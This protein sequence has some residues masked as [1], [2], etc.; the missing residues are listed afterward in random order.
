MILSNHK[1]LIWRTFKK[2][3]PPSHHNKPKLTHAGQRI[4][5]QIIS[6]LQENDNSSTIPDIENPV[7]DT[8]SD[9]PDCEMNNSIIHSI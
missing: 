4:V 2:R 5:H 9:P 7:D 3:H 1:Q 6:D 8:P